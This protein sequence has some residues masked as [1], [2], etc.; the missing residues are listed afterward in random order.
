MEF[1]G[2]IFAGMF[3]VFVI[4]SLHG[5]THKSVTKFI[6][7]TCTTGLAKAVQSY[8]EKKRRAQPG[9]EPGTSCTRSRNH[10]TRPLSRYGLHFANS[11]NGNP[12]KI[13][14]LE[15]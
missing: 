5:S 14:P 9:F 13:I 4:L 12:F 15:H 3:P 2:Q 11:L 6:I 8:V 7:H 1:F 10:T